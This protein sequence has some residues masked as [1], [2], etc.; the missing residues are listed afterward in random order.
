MIYFVMQL[1]FW[2]YTHKHV[3]DNYILPFLLGFLFVLVLF[4]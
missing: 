2:L 1:H 4:A 3:T